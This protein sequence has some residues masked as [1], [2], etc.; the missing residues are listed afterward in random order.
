MNLRE[1]QNLLYQRITDPDRTNESVSDERGLA[2]GVLEALV[3]GDDR[4]SAVDRIGI[5]ADAHFYRVLD[6]LV[7]DFP[8][9]LAV[10]GADN[11]AAW[12]RS[13]C[14]SIPLRSRLY[15][16]RVSAWRTFSTIIR[17]PNVGRSSPTSR[18]SKEQFSMFPEGNWQKPFGIK[19]F[20]S[21]VP[22]SGIGAQFALD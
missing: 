3:H 15:F 16:T 21:Y 9:T 5:Y 14:W 19:L 8:A 2:R 20:G 18:G 7:E 10:L 17:L 11:F 4:L 13:T 22:S 6:C 1:L 12:L